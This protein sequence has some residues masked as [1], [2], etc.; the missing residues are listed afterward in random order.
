MKPIDR[1][2][3]LRG[4][5]G[6]AI[7]LPMLD[8]MVP[9][10]ARANGALTKVG[11]NGAPKRLV[12][13]FTACGQG[14]DWLRV[15]NAAGGG[16][17]L[18]PALMPLERHKRDLIIPIGV[19]NQ[20][21]LHDAA[22]IDPGHQKP[23]I[24]L[25]CCV[26]SRNGMGGGVSFDQI[27]AR[28]VSTGTRFPSVQLAVHGRGGHAGGLSY[29]A[30][31]V[32]APA[33]SDPRQVF[34]RLFSDLDTEQ[35][36][37]ARLAA[38]RRSV[39]D[40]IKEDYR[41]LAGRLSGDDKLKLE[42]HFEGIREVETRLTGTSSQAA[43]G[44]TKP[45]QPAAAAGGGAGL[46]STGDAQIK[47]LTTALACDLTRV[48]SLMYEGAGG[49]V[50]LP[51]FPK[52]LHDASHDYGPVGWPLRNRYT[53]WFAGRF[54][55]LLD[56]LRAIDEAGR[57][58]L[59]NTVVYWCSEH[60]AGNHNYDMMNILVAGSGGGYFRT[61]RVLSFPNG[62]DGLGYVQ[63][64]ANANRATGPSQAE[65][66]VSFMNAMGVPA[67]TFG[68]PDQCRGPLPGMTG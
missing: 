28:E 23:M 61:G 49:N 31:G 6:A 14:A 4:F 40:G 59:D 57:S 56:Q 19:N 3:V 17:E 1:R 18:T 8:I 32:T 51:G 39:L 58:L 9:R 60:G 44:C 13:F 26:S 30:P 43:A 68:R 20:S 54:A 10:P 11:P 24:N 62:T 55:M 34:A 27:I 67:T 29:T 38:E 41:S 48:I 35:T 12:T 2:T 5:G 22:S 50:T 53:E 45:A 47:L 42:S 65:L 52:G 15:R 16:I 66:Y 64:N 7:A 63:Y 36:A 37:F 33:I 46:V 21:A 25:T